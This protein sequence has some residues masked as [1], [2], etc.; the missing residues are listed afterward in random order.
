M[1]RNVKVVDDLFGKKV[2]VIQDIR[3]KVNLWSVYVEIPIHPDFLMEQGEPQNEPP[4]E[5]QNEPQN[6]NSVEDAIL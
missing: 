4:N 3:F 6:A 1:E 2:V 5:P